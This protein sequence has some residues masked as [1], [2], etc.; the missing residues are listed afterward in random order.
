MGFNGHPT[1]RKIPRMALKK[2]KNQLLIVELENL[3]VFI[4]RSDCIL[5]KFVGWL[6]E[7][8]VSNAIGNTCKKCLRYL[9]WP[10][11]CQ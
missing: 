11:K 8:A 5:T 6:S 10:V 1:D 4:F 3:F 9:I 2:S 7:T